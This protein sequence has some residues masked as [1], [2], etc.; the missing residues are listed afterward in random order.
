[1]PNQELVFLVQSITSVLFGTY[2]LSDTLSKANI[3][4]QAV[5]QVFNGEPFLFPIPDNAPT[6]IPRIILRNRDETY[7]STIALNRVEI[8]YKE[9]G[10]PTKE[11]TAIC[12]GYL[13]ILGSFST[14]LRAKWNTAIVRLGLVMDL[15]SFTENPVGLIV[16]NYIKEDTIKNPEQIAVHSLNRIQFDDLA[17]NRWCRLSSDKTKNSHG[18]RELLRVIIDVNTLPDETYSFNEPAIIGF[19]DKAIRHSL[20]SLSLLLPVK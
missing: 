18:E 19:Y 20:D 6:E 11:P 17:I 2:D 1:M 12:D 10:V 15:I 13:G 9:K 16:K 8:A 5:K 4:H 3:L 7:Q 14:V